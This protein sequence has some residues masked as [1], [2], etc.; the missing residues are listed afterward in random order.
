[1]SDSAGSCS[2]REEVCSLF[3][4]YQRPLGRKMSTFYISE[5][6]L[7]H[8]VRAYV[9]YG[10]PED[11][12]LKGGRSEA[13][14]QRIWFDSC[15][16]TYEGYPPTILYSARFRDGLV[17]DKDV[18]SEFAKDFRFRYTLWNEEF[19]KH[20][21]IVFQYVSPKRGAVLCSESG[22]DHRD[23]MRT[24]SGHEGSMCSSALYRGHFLTYC[25]VNI[26][27]YQSQKFMRRKLF[28]V[29]GLEVPNLPKTWNKNHGRADI[30]MKWFHAIQATLFCFHHHRFWLN[31]KF[32]GEDD[33]DWLFDELLPRFRQAMGHFRIDDDFN[34]A[35]NCKVLI[36]ILSLM[37]V[38]EVEY[39]QL[40][41]FI[42]SEERKALFGPIIKSYAPLAE[43]LYIKHHGS[44]HTRNLDLDIQTFMK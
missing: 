9:N 14:D 15:I 19:F 12:F 24:V 34:T 43:Q 26:E 38:I 31:I 25:L 7:F 42:D 17:A 41:S 1:M 8:E 40:N 18:Y 6:E 23:F 22:H 20:C 37:Q 4:P 11:H 28:T 27:G 13:S 5:P 32:R 36:A 39:C 10:V 16:Q 29:L 33:M 21:R 44:W 30:K 2:L 35:E 3:A